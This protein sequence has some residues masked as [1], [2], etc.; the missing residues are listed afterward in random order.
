[1]AQIFISE[2]ASAKQLLEQKAKGAIKKLLQKNQFDTLTGSDVEVIVNDYPQMTS[3][4]GVDEVS[5]TVKVKVHK[6]T[7]LNSPG[8]KPVKKA[9]PEVPPG[10]KLK[11]RSEI[12]TLE[13]YLKLD[14]SKEEMRKVKG[15]LA[16]IKKMLPA[17]SGK[18]SMRPIMNQ[19]KKH[20]DLMDLAERLGTT[21]IKEFFEKFK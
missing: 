3:T 10:L 11:L 20:G 13:G 19:Y 17:A 8:G 15:Q 16:A 1:M 12:K 2:S 9:K 5:F 21:L 14:L 7:R 4:V 18:K 6:P